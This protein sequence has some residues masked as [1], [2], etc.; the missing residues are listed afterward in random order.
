MGIS[1]TPTMFVEGR[2]ISGFQQGELEAFLEAQSRK[3]QPSP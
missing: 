2:L 1:G 3:G